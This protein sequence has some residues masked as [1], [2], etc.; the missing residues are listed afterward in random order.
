MEKRG[1]RE[2]LLQRFPLLPLRTAGEWSHL[3]GAVV[4]STTG[5]DLKAQLGR[6]LGQSTAAQPSPGRVGPGDPGGP[7]PTGIL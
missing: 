6:E 5:H 4:D 7:F 1:G 3:P 2:L